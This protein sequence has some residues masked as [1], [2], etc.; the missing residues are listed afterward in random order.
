MADHSTHGFTRRSFIKGA[1]A[2]TAAGA[3]VGCSP[4]TKNLEETDVKQEAPETQ[5]FSGVC[6]GNCS[7]GCFLNV[8][9]RDGQVVRTSARDLPNTEYNRICPRGLTHVGRIYSAERVLY[10]MKRVGERGSNDFERI[11]WDE[12][13]DIITEKWKKY[14][15]EFGPQSIMFF[16][17][18]GNHALYGGSGVP[19]GGCSK[20]ENI[21][22][23]TTYVLDIDAGTGYGA[24]R[25][26]GGADLSNELTDTK[27]AK[28]KVVWGSNP[29]ISLPQAFHF[30]MEAKENG[31]RFIVIDPVYNANAAKADWWVPVKGG[32]DGALA[33]GVLNVLFANGWI[34]DDTIRNKT[35]CGLLIKEDGA[36]L[37]MS[38]LGVEP[39]EGPVDPAT[40]KPKVIDLPAVWDEAQGKAVPY[41]ETTTPALEGVGEVEGFVVQTVYENA[42]EQIAPW[43][44]EKASE[45]CGVSVDDIR[46]LARVYHEDGPVS[47]SITQ[48][49]NH[50]QNAHYTGWLLYLVCLLTGNFGKPGA[51]LGASA[52][53]LP[54]SS[55]LTSKRP[56]I[57]S[58]LLGT[59]LPA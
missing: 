33:L 10:P 48:G 16:K 50:Y 19:G 27:N 46:E 43:T 23:C 59:L 47:T 2:L 6:R 12:A 51:A 3:L 13:L 28:T 35:N 38:D 58:T 5:I 53:Y 42:M 49:H 11:S 37:R 17:G 9:V 56:A 18:T 54:R 4:Q 32:T 57:L 14:R 40:G 22:G 7:G 55:T 29:A 39:T 45:V 20:F 36:Y 8:H 52:E 34:D 41:N 31:T 30:M 21:L 26:H 25:A 44:P 1:A 24:Q 15:E